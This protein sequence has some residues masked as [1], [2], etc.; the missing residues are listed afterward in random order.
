MAT[1]SAALRTLP[2]ASLGALD[3]TPHAVGAPA[4]RPTPEAETDVLIER[5]RELESQAQSKNQRK[6]S[7]KKGSTLPPIKAEKYKMIYL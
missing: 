3:T 6:S 4:D 7:E 2:S 5:I 1:D